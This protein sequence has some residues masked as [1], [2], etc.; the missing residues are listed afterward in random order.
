MVEIIDILQQE[1]RNLE[2]LLQVMEQELEIFD[3]GERRTTR[4]L[5]Q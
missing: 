2:K 3:R 4:F 1:H 5:E